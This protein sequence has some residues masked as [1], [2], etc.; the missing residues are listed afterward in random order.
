MVKEMK[1]ERIYLLKIICKREIVADSMK[2]KQKFDFRLMKDMNRIDSRE[3][4]KN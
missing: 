1:F 4:N 3:K 2:R